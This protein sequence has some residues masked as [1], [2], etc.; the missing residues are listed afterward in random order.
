MHPHKSIKERLLHAL[1]FELL[2]IALCAP[3]GAWLLDY[4]LA[5]MGLLTMMI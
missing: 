3:L 1:I 5:H 4:P 2:A